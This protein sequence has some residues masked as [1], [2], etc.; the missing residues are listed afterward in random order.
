[1]KHW[2]ALQQLF[3]KN[4]I[5]FTALASIIIVSTYWLVVASD[6]YVSEARVV[7][8]RTDLSSGGAMDISSLIGAS[9]GG[10][11]SD[12]L[13][14]RSHLQSIDMLLQLD[15]QLD[16]R[17]HYSQWRRDP[18]SRLW[19]A[20]PDMEVFHQHYLDRV[21]VELD[22]FTGV[23]VI[24]AQAYSPEVS[25]ALAQRIVAEGEAFMNRLAHQLAQ[26]QVTFL[27]TQVQTMASR[28]QQSRKAVLDF[29]DTQGVAAPKEAAESL[30]AIV[31]KLQAQRSEL[32]TQRGALSA[33]LVAQ[34]P[35]IVMLDQQIQAID[36]Q[37]AQEQARL[38]SSQGTPLNRKLEAFGLLERQA[39][40]DQAL[41]ETALT[42]L[43][44][45]R[46]E[47]TRTI[48]KLSVIQSPSLPDRP[49]EPRR[50]Y[51]TLVFLLI[52]ALL[53]SVAQL[54]HAIV[55]DHQD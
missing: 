1:M 53:A 30:V 11:R 3:H 34:H 33:Y 55:R 20:S 42:A 2:A 35:N 52:A 16:L 9:A 29:Q 49:T 54:V 37:I 28:A 7:V 38:A 6:R 12:Q 25:Q 51:N 10:N 39:Q 19:S 17:Q 43:E 45:G 18:I 13:L 36:R 15:K 14:L 31:G 40:F 48:K 41:Y 50:L 22:E 24:R 21:S 46:V 32:Q 8:Q 5:W 47:A 26:A 4:P 44:R 27:E 23:L